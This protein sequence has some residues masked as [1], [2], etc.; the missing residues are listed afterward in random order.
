MSSFIPP[1]EAIVLAGGKG[2]RLASVVS[3]LPKPL[4]PVGGRAFLDHLVDQLEADGAIDRVVLSTGHLADR[5]RDWAC[6]R[7]GQATL[8]CIE[9]TEPLGTGGA[10]LGAVDT[11]HGDTV[12]VTNGD[13]MVLVK[14]KDV[15]DSHFKSQFDFTMVAVHVADASRYGKLEITHNQVTA[16]HEKSSGAEPGYINAGIY[17]VNRKCLDI[18]QRKACSFEQDILPSLVKSGIG[19]Y[20]TDRPFCDIGVPESYF[21]ASE[22]LSL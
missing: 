8:H 22:V 9:E 20:I 10:I 7:T 2:T 18:F 13:S 6:L 15:I 4:A 14:I 5:M 12:L 21:A 3:D 17:I 19:A 11:C 1:I 16:F